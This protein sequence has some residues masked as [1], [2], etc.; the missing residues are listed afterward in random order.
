M[1]K[2]AASISGPASNCLIRQNSHLGISSGPT[3]WPENTIS[4]PSSTPPLA[5]RSPPPRSRSN[6]EPCLSA[7]FLPPAPMPNQQIGA[8]PA[9]PWVTQ[10][11][12]WPQT[13]RPTQV[14]KSMD[15]S[16]LGIADSPSLASTVSRAAAS[17]APGRTPPAYRSFSRLPSRI[18]IHSRCI[19]LITDRTYW[20]CRSRLYPP[21][22][23]HLWII[24]S[25]VF[26]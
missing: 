25:D 2:F 12:A 10:F 1:A 23:E 21:T 4:A 26:V 15:Q 16:K 14:F 9:A 6:F 24:G 3:L 11:P 19:W 18:P 5:F 20:I 22:T 8:S 7:P 17:S 13:S